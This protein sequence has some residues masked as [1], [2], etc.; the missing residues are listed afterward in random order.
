MENVHRET[1]LRS[2]GRLGII[3]EHIIAG[4][5][6][7][8]GSIGIHFHGIDGNRNNITL[9]NTRERHKKLNLVFDH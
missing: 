4:L 3:Y 9:L 6:R 2:S 1:P 7:Q 5:G 8:V